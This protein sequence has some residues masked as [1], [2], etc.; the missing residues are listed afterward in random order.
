[1]DV[2]ARTVVRTRLTTVSALTLKPLRAQQSSRFEAISQIMEKDGLCIA[3][4]FILV[5]A[6]LGRIFP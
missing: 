3:S 2:S 5:F 6:N 1:M 4:F